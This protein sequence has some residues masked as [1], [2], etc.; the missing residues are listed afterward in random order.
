MKK[1]FDT[2]NPSGKDIIR[3]LISP[4]SEASFSESY[5]RLPSLQENLQNLMF[6]INISQTM[7]GPT[8]S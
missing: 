3:G 4:H 1:K 8:R 2:L 5:P 6:D 7:H